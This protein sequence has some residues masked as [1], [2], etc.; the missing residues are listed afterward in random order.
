VWQRPAT[1]FV[2]EFLGYN[3]TAAFGTLVAVRPEGLTLTPDLAGASAPEAEAIAVEV[4]DRTFRRD[5]FRVRVRTAAGE[6]LDVAVPHAVAGAALPRPG[7]PASVVLDR[8]RAVP[9]A[10]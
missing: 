10:R 5:H 4:V 3:V 7:L 8:S 6:V 1:P 2:A 9:L